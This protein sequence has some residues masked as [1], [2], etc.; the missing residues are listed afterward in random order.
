MNTRKRKACELKSNYPD[1]QTNNKKLKLSE[2]FG[3]FWKSNDTFEGTFIRNTINGDGNCLFRAILYC[4]LQN[5]DAHGELRQEVC[6]YMEANATHFSSFIP[7]NITGL[8][9][10]LK[11]MRKG[12]IWGTFIELIAASEMLGFNFVVLY[13]ES[14]NI[15][16]QHKHNDQF[17]T[18]YL[19]WYNGNH[20]NSLFRRDDFL[21][22]VNLRGGIKQDFDKIKKQISTKKMKYKTSETLA[23]IQKQISSQQT[24]LPSLE[25]PNMLKNKVI[26][27]K[28]AAS[29]G[30]GDAHN[31]PYLYLRH[32]I[33]P[34]RFVSGEKKLQN[35]KNELKETYYLINN[36][37]LSCSQS[38]LQRKKGKGEVIPFSDEIEDIIS[39]AHNQFKLINVKHFGINTTMANIKRMNFYWANM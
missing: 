30:G 14:L 18:I 6:N 22:R 3:T 33:V 34:K 23:S 19:E 37:R 26:K 8:L 32:K 1:C 11:N 31:E 16:C 24:N 27:I 2:E 13:H 17:K 9:R 35:W 12:A 4:V 29:K 25:T 39:K 10:Y 15:Y 20:F 5:D 21:V 36:A 7:G 28:Y 38:I